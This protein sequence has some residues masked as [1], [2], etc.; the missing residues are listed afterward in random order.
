MTLGF[1]PLKKRF[2]GSFI[3]SMMSNLWIYDGEL[4]ADK[5]ALILSAD[6]P[7]F[8]D[9][10][11][12]A[13]YRDTIAFLS[14]DHRTLTASVQGDDGSWKEFMLAHYRRTA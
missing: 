12:V 10:T 9:P 8:T 6:G 11:K 2:V 4:D 5:T 7:S 3:G 1:D 14:D 13:K